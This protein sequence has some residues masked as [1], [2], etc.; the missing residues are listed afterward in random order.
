MIEI[1]IILS[2]FAT[3][4]VAVLDQERAEKTI[5]EDFSN[6]KYPRR[7]KNVIFRA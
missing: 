2:A 7:G 3:A 6:G 4:F 5:S 1:L